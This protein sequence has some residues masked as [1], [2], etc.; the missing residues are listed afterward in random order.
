MNWEPINPIGDFG[1]FRPTVLKRSMLGNAKLFRIK[2]QSGTIVI[3]EDLKESIENSG[4]NPQRF[5]LLECS[6]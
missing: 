5:D 1:T 2:G 3:R 6:D 4:L